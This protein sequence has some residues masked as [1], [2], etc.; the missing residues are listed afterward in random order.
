[1]GGNRD[2]GQGPA[3]GNRGPNGSGGMGNRGPSQFR[4]MILIL[5]SP[6]LLSI[7]FLKN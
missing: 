4:G 1:M 7:S 2:Q 3:M 5:A 6:T